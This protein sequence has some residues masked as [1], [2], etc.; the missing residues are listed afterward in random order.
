MEAKLQIHEEMQQTQKALK[1]INKLSEQN[2]IQVRETPEFNS[3]ALVV[4]SA[5]GQNIPAPVNI[6]G[7]AQSSDI[8]FGAHGYT[9]DGS[10]PR[11]K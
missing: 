2:N 9:S 3:P 4:G 7:L 8:H 1:A 5:A 11:N 6:H 10:H